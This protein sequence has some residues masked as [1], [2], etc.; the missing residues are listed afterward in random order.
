MPVAKELLKWSGG[1][2]KT[3]S[4]T[5]TETSENK[6]VW[7]KKIFVFTHLGIRK[8]EEETLPGFQ[9]SIIIT[10]FQLIMLK[11]KTLVSFQKIPDEVLMLNLCSMNCQARIMW[12]VVFT[13]SL[14]IG[15][16]FFSFF[17]SV[18]TSES[19]IRDIV[20]SVCQ[21]IFIFF[22]GFFLCSLVCVLSKPKGKGF[23]RFNQTK[24]IF[25]F[26]S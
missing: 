21:H 23:Y 2:A 7:E 6:K 22:F 10:P 25:I 5:W 18:N 20:I 3:F 15:G 26:N 4:E 14:I 17:M 11:P 16:D 24:Q 12:S 19:E 1:N 13:F 8:M 9:V